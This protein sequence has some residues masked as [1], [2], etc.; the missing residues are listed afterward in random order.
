MPKIRVHGQDID[1]VIDVS[2]G[3]RLFDE[4]IKAGIYIENDCGGVGSCGKCKVVIDGREELACEYTVKHDIDVTVRHVLSKPAHSKE[5]IH[6]DPVSPILKRSGDTVSFEYKGK[7][8]SYKGSGNRCK[9]VLFDIGTTTVRGQVL[10]IHTGDILD[11]AAI[12]NKQIPYG[13]DVISRI[14]YSEKNDALSLLQKKLVETLNEIIEALDVEKDEIDLIFLAGNSI[15]THFLYGIDPRSIRYQPY[16][17]AFTEKDPV[18]ASSLGIDV[19]EDVLIVSVPL[20]AS[21]VGGD[22]VAGIIGAGLYKT[23]DTTLYIDIGTN[24]EIVLG[25]KDW[26]ISAAASAGPNFEGSE[27]DC[28]MLAQDGAID[29]VTIENGHVSAHTIGDAEPRGICGCGLINTIA[30]LFDNQ[31]IDKKGQLIPSRMGKHFA[32]GRF[33]ISEDIYLSQTDIDNFIK[34]KGAVFAACQTLINKV[35]ISKDEIKDVIISGSFGKHLDIG[36]A[37]KLGMLPKIKGGNYRFIGNGTLLGMHMALLDKDVAEEIFTVAGKVTYVELSEEP[38]Y[39][40]N[41]SAALFI[42]H[43]DSSLF[44]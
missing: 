4:L 5:L 19:P 41:F 40:D 18:P 8:Y 22:I 44:K 6:L 20:V 29:D 39:M 11:E 34:A 10:D 15:I 17:P 26:M 43:T 28:G 38:D 32:D 27:I 35:G 16:V 21:Y 42:P 31:W 13:S 9:A 33:M 36:N 2:A 25:N 24:G 12:Y 23:E 37:I 3:V 14:V 30:A 1:E 7:T